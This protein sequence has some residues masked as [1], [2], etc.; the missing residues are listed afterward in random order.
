M[1]TDLKEFRE[2]IGDLTAADPAA[3]EVV[4]RF[5]ELLNA[6][7]RAQSAASMALHLAEAMVEA[8]EAEELGETEVQPE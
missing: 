4:Y 3:A 1:A 7:E 2:A 6:D 8:E 5:V